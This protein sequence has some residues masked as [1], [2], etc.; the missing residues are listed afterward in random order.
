MYTEEQV[1]HNCRFEKSDMPG[2][3]RELAIDAGLGYVRTASRHSFEPMEALVTFLTRMSYPNRWEDKIAFLGGQGRSAYIEAFT[4]SAPFTKTMPWTLML[5][6]VKNGVGSLRNLR[7]PCA[8]H[9]L[10]SSA[11]TVRM[12][13]VIGIWVAPEM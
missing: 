11:V 9:V 10:G 7:Q 5:V 6:T 1:W 8:P 2:L 4:T 3:L 12:L 13:H